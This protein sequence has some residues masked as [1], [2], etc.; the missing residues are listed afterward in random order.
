M[1]FDFILCNEEAELF[2]I[3]AVTGRIFKANYLQHHPIIV[4][5]TVFL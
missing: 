2:P 4:L 3:Y 5:L 1:T